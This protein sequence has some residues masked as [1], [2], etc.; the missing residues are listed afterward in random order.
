MTT[1]GISSGDGRAHP[2]DEADNQKPV[3]T[4]V[5]LPLALRRWYKMYAA[6]QDMT[7]YDVISNILLE[8]AHNH[9]YKDERN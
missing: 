5:Q 2:G 7:L 8:F 1:G 9:G 6:S 4:T 3:K